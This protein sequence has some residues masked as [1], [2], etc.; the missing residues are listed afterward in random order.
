MVGRTV[1]HY[2]LI[3]K[4][5]QGGMGVV[6]RAED[7]NLRRIVAIKFL[8]PDLISGDV[9][10]QRFKKEAQ[11]A[12][13]LN[14]PNIAT[15][16]HLVEIEDDVFFVM[17]YV[18]GQDLRDILEQ[19]EILSI[20]RI[21]KYARQIAAGLKAAHD[22]NIIHRDIKPENIRITHDDH[23][24]IMD[25][26]IA[27]L[28]GN[29]RLTQEGSSLGTISYMSPEQTRG[30]NVDKRTD[31]WSFGAMLYEM[32]TGEEPFKGHYNEAVVYSILNENPEPIEHLRAHVPEFL[33]ILTM[34]SLQKN[35]ENRYQSIDDIIIALKTTSTNV[36]EI[37]KAEIQNS[38]NADLTS[39][40]SG[41]LRRYLKWVLPVALFVVIIIVFSVSQNYF[42][43][44]SADKNNSVL[45]GIA[46]VINEHPQFI[47]ELL[48]ITDT[49]AF[50]NK[51]N[52]LRK[53]MRIAVG[54]QEDFASPEGCYV[55]V[56]GLNQVEAVLRY[57]NDKFR[58]IAT[59]EI[60]ETLA[61]RY[62]G[63]SSIW[64]RDLSQ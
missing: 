54:N 20:D 60:L 8:R 27:K 48:S 17:E 2:Q 45:T 6:Y 14:H 64:I 59:D 30:Q 18:D 52:E 44:N 55:F 19:S 43:E 10:R 3:E 5:G 51:L 42:P 35:P 25:F 26:G 7:L 29:T 21:I 50:M 62:S 11:A 32:L 23:I 38:Q 58:N 37:E 57:Q 34:K 56:L 33:K 49:P 1:S 39:A 63:K 4:I 15:I 61:D 53:S 40:R 31:I 13:S 36:I 41:L 12:A 28:P 16:Y 46:T 47:M 22:K 9:Q 24:K